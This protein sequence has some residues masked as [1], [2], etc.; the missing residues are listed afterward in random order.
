MNT[1]VHF[2]RWKPLDF[3]LT[4]LAIVITMGIIVGL[5]YYTLNTI[6]V[7]VT[8][9]IG[10]T[11][12]GIWNGSTDNVERAKNRHKPPGPNEILS[13]SLE[14]EVKEKKE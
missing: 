7:V 12:A 6:V 3:G 9:I 8:V 10:V 1:R 5:V 14:K 11:I 2:L 4:L 13:F